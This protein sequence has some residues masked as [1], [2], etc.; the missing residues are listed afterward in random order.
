MADKLLSE[1]C[2][3]YCK[4]LESFS[5]T[6]GAIRNK[7]LKI[8]KIYDSDAVEIIRYTLEE[9]SNTLDV[10]YQYYCYGEI[11]RFTVTIPIKWLDLDDN[12][13][14]ELVEA[15]I[16]EDKRRLKAKYGMEDK[17]G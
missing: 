17:N 13:I 9:C 11:G 2:V 8:V 7:L 3:S 12:E 5:E 15:K 14:I 6:E 1:A 10:L 4:L 16:E